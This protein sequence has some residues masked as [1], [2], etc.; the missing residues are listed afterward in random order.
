[1]S[2]LSVPVFKPCVSIGF[3]LIFFSV[4]F[5]FLT[6]TQLLKLEVQSVV[7]FILFFLFF[8]DDMNVLE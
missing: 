1:M 4:V 3:V 2:S 8:L 6:L 7:L 5:E